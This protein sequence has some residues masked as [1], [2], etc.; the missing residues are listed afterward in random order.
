[1]KNEKLLDLKIE[2]QDIEEEIK[3]KTVDYRRLIGQVK[4]LKITR[5]ERIKTLMKNIK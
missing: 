1:M 3:K 2:I 4:L 5:E